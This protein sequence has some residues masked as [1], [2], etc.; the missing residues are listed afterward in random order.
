[1]A[2]DFSIIVIL[3]QEVVLIFFFSLGNTECECIYQIF[4]L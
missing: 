4:H 3:Q 1:M 2:A